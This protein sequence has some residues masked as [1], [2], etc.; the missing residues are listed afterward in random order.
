MSG[1]VALFRIVAKGRR[2]CYAR[3]MAV[4]I[5]MLGDI[6]GMPGVHAVEQRMAGIRERWQPDLVIANAEN[7]HNGSGL[8]PRLYRRLGEAGVDGMTLGDHVY[9]RNQ[10]VRTLESETNIVRP[11]NLSRQASGLRWM[12]LPIPDRDLSI[13][14]MLVL[15]R[16]FSNLPADDPFETVDAIL[17]EMPDLN[18]LVIVEIHAEATSEK[19]AMGY[20]LDGRVAAVIG[21]HTHVP[22]ADAHILA[23]GTAY[24]TDMGM[25]GPHVSILGRSVENVLTHMTTGMHAPFDVAEGDPRVNGVF[26]EI[27]DQTGRAQQIERI[28]LDADPHVAPFVGEQ[29]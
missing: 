28:Q 17:G 24:L 26:V 4:R 6:V 10:I 22:T 13:Y 7:A 16:I 23:G 19:Q 15:G 2:V 25:C 8:T 29:T 18:P 5:V 27:D 20:H 12:K 3:R 14:V 9:K 21:S 11:A 1:G